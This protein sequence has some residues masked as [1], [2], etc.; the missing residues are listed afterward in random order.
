[1]RIAPFTVDITPPIGFPL[2][3]SPNDRCDSRIFAR[4]LVIEDAGQ[5]VVLAAAEIIGLYGTPYLQWR[6]AIAKAAQTRESN[7]LIHAVHQH[8]S[9]MPLTREVLELLPK[10]KDSF[11]GEMEFWDSLPV[12]IARGI[13]TAIRPGK[14]GRWQK[15]ARISTAERRLTGL[16]SN[17]RLV[18][19]DGKVW[20]MRWSM[21]HNPKLSAEPVGRIDPLLR[22]IGFHARNGALLASLH[23]YA[24][25][26]MAAYGRRMVSADVPGRALAYLNEHTKGR[27]QHIYFTGC[28]ADITFGKFT[29]RQKERSLNVLGRCLGD[30][31]IANVETLIGSAP[32]SAPALKLLEA[33]MDVPLDL[34][35]CKPERY[36]RELKKAETRAAATFAASNFYITKHWKR[37]QRPSLFRLTLAP[38]THILSVLSETAVEYQLYA[39]SLAPEDFI[40]CAGYRDGTFNYLCTDR[41]FDEGGYEPS[42]SLAPKG[43]EAAYRACIARTLEELPFYSPETPK[44]INGKH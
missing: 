22:S 25:H 9:L 18:G 1:M 40:A 10:A 11:A 32:G 7:V 23:F 30:G 26:P 42:A 14:K 24:T 43:F 4:G 13:Q 39:Q 31:L 21:N 6:N 35:R 2:A 3:Y 29:Y 5:R 19:A 28:G 15:V 44:D 41:M 8:D 34:P 38:R 20:A 27:G 37:F 16:A 33:R 17:R 12:R 36:A